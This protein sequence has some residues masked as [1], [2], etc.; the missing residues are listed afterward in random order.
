MF[1]QTVTFEQ[2]FPKTVAEKREDIP[3]LFLGTMNSMTLCHVRVPF[4]C[5]RVSQI[6]SHLW[7]TPT[8]TV[9]RSVERISAPTAICINTC[10][11]VND[12]LDR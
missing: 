4:K 11:F 10:N 1:G 7:C 5:P 6:I 2:R 12:Y 8:D 9:S 3:V